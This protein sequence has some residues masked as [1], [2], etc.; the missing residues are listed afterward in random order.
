VTSCL[1]IRARMRCL[2]SG[3]GS[4]FGRSRLGQATSF[5]SAGAGLVVDTVDYQPCYRTEAGTGNAMGFVTW[6]TN[7]AV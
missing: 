5:R 2:T 1:P 7:D 3:G 4:S 6:K